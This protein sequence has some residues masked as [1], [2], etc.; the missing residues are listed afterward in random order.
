MPTYFGKMAIS[1][2]QLIA[3]CIGGLFVFAIWLAST[4]NVAFL[5][6]NTIIVSILFIY[7]AFII[8]AIYQDRQWN[9][10]DGPLW[11]FIPQI[12]PCWASSLFFFVSLG[13]HDD[14]SVKSIFFLLSIC[15]FQW[16]LSSTFAMFV[17]TYLQMSSDIYYIYDQ[18]IANKF[19]QKMDKLPL[20]T[21]LVYGLFGN[22][23]NN[24]YSTAK[25]SHS[26][27]QT[28]PSLHP[29]IIDIVASYVERD[30]YEYPD[31]ELQ[32]DN[33]EHKRDQ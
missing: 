16:I 32:V 29:N 22:L 19:K 7:G 31:F 13:F 3:I 28:L 26:E 6:I 27:Y 10:S 12:I 23:E 21:Y 15:Q 33:N 18:E 24:S 4:S 20:N 5:V 2:Q 14:S 1:K 11:L 25:W 8:F 30:P 9:G 17:S